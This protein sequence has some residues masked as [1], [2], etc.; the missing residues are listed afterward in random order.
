[1]LQ[2]VP[3]PRGLQGPPGLDGDDGLPAEF[4]K[5][6]T[7]IQWRLQGGSWSDLVAL[8]DIK[9]D[10]GDTSEITKESII[11]TL[12]G[13]YESFIRIL[14]TGIL[15]GGELT[16]NATHTDQ[17]DLGA[18]SATFINSHTDVDNP[19]ITHVTWPAQTGITVTNLA[20][21]ATT[22]VRINSSGV[23]SQSNTTATEIERRS[24]VE[25]GW[26]DHPDNTTLSFFYQEPPTNIN[27][28]SQFNDFLEALKQFNIEGNN[29]TAGSTNLTIQRSAGRVFDNN[30]NYTN[31]IRN[32]HIISTGI[33]NPCDIYYY[34]KDGSGGWVND[35]EAVT[36]INP[37][38]YDDGTGILADV[39][40]GKWTIQLLSFYS[41]YESNDVQYG[42]AV[43]DTYEQALANLKTPVDINPYNEADVFRGWLMVKQGAT[44]LSDTDEAVF[45]AAGIF[46]MNDAGSGTI[47]GSGGEVNL[48]ANIGTEGTG[49]Y[50]NKTAV[51]LNFKNLVSKSSDLTITNNPTNHTVEFS[52]NSYT[53]PANHS[54]SIITQ[55]SS[56]RFVTDA[57]K[58]TWNGKADKSSRTSC[59]VIE[60]DFFSSNA[61]SACPGLLGAS[62]SSGATG[63]VTGSIN[64]P[65]VI[66]LRDST[67]ANGNYRFMTEVSAF[68]IAGG[69]TAIFVFQAR[70]ARS[71]ASFWM[72][73]FDST[74]IQTQPTDG[75]WFQSVGDG[76]NVTLRGRCK[77]N[78]GPTD[79][80][81]PYQL[82]L[83]TWYTGKIE[84][85]SD[86]TLVT[87]TLYAE[88][89]T[90]LWQKTVNA[91]IPT[92]SGRE[93]GFGII[94]GETSTDAAADILYIDYLKMEINKTLT[95]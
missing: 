7:H 88:N 80:A 24:F 61:S 28:Q 3:G 85:N 63:L 41:V 34:Y 78:A 30:S 37:N 60:S 46:G 1:M 50:D 22:Y 75:V 32:P 67:T 4:Q 36:S 5:T 71:T 6:A 26:I 9:G 54:P 79:T 93:T 58:T 48:A 44:D 39:P 55:D 10:P 49:I 13:D 95:R 38:K 16:Q 35:N 18:G 59:V 77:N 90:Q 14:S 89:G 73:W 21:D 20:T 19:T 45:R 15:T 76:T 64:H 86:A 40:S 47:G 84:V 56:N 66:Y 65:G 69:E 43:Y 68:R 81:D 12:T 72:G 92:A 70:N 57:E 27:L 33:E 83:N 74:A 23:I 11:L 31:D 62:T 87:F 53:H 42:Q 29:Y 2:K 51:T 25:I 82:T 52:V 17:F 94:A 91:N 8:T